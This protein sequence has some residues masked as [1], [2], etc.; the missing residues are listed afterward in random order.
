MAYGCQIKMA[1]KSDEEEEDKNNPEKKE[2][3]VIYGTYCMKGRNDG[4]NR[5][6]KKE[7]EVT[8]HSSC[9]DLGV[10]PL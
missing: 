6:Q 10:D 7:W 1:K 2:E 8:I 5:A 3:A 4:E 9:M